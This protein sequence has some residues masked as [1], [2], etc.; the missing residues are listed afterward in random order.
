MRPLLALLPLAPLLAACPGQRFDALKE[1]ETGEVRAAFDAHLE[2]IRRRDVEAYLAGYLNAPDFVY[3]GPGGVS[4]GF[5]GFA[6]ARR[7]APDFPDSLVAGAP[8][9]AWLAPGV[10][11]LA[12][13]YA[14]R[15]GDAAGQGWSERV[16]VK[17]ADGWRI[18]VTG[19]IPTTP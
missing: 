12:Y 3:I 11:Y 2:A 17:T 14:A 16:F 9:L 4:R 6:V 1:R 5:R 7:A 19:V 15:Q 18:A 8:E 10:V 13:P